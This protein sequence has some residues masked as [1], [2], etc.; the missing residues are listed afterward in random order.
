MKIEV[1]DSMKMLAYSK[2]LPIPEEGQ[3]KLSGGDK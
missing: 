3:E 1:N 2:T